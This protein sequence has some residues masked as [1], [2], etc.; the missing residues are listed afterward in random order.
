LTE[1]ASI[2]LWSFDEHGR[3]AFYNAAIERLTGVQPG[4]L[5][6]RQDWFQLVHP[7]DRDRIADA[8][9]EAIRQKR[10]FKAEY[11]LRFADGD[12]GWVVGYGA[13]NHSEDGAY[14]GASGLVLNIDEQIYQLKINE[15]F[16]KLE[17]NIT[18]GLTRKDILSALMQDLAFILDLPL[19][20]VGLLDKTGAFKIYASAGPLQDYLRKIR[21]NLDS[22]GPG[23]LAIRSGKPV[24]LDRDNPD[25]AD[26]AAILKQHHLGGALAIP[27]LQTETLQ[28]VLLAY[29]PEEKTWSD[30]TRQR[31]LDIAPRVG[32]AL[33]DMEQQEWLRLFSTAIDHAS[34]PMMIVN[35]DRVIMFV[36]Q[37][38]SD[39]YGYATSEVSGKTLASIKKQMI[40]MADRS[41]KQRSKALH[42]GRARNPG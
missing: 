36:N 5:K 3:M 9:D 18:Q 42:E 30:R 31:I 10:N 21:V 27:V 41:A 33:A 25:F 38:F 24:M 7:R 28:G 32:L 13:P 26:F 37:A 40:F 22:K 35:R 23:A 14:R 19:M 6:F 12:Y 11:R 8:A 15:A 17:H 34:N 2:V 16:A 29:W 4:T 20:W 39:S 1:A